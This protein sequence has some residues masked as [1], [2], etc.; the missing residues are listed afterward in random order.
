MSSTSGQRLSAAGLTYPFTD[1][2]R[3][4]SKLSRHQASTVVQVRCG[5][6]PLNSFLFRIKKSDTDKCKACPHAPGEEAPAETI[7]H[8]LFECRAYAEQRKRLEKVVGQGNLTA[9]G[10]MKDVK[11]MKALV[12][13]IK[14]TK[15]LEGN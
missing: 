12:T 4:K 5:H 8:F 11:C 3:E 10:V 1:F 6:F 9:Q 2:H 13:Y 14:N 7:K 15:R